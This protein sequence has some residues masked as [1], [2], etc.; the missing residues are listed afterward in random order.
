MDQYGQIGPEKGEFTADC[1]RIAVVLLERRT[2]FVRFANRGTG[3][4]VMFT[5]VRGL[6]CL[7]VSSSGT[8]RRPDGVES[9]DGKLSPHFVRVDVEGR[10]A[11]WF[12][13]RLR[14]HPSYVSE[15]LRITNGVDAESVATLIEEVGRQMYGD[16]HETNGA[17][18]RS[19]V[20]KIVND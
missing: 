1:R 3:F 20:R 14:K 12:D 4:Q 17:E 11:Y 18:Y 10:G 13:M 7:S 19:V 16:A 6:L 9:M 5:P 15:K 2:V 8:P